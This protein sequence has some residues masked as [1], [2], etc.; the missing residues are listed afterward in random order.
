MIRRPPR[1]TLFP[2]T[3]L[4][5]SY[6]L[7]VVLYEML[8]GNLPHD[9][10][11]P[12]ALAVKHVSEPAQPPKEVNPEIPDGMNALVL[13][14]LA[15]RAEDRHASAAEVA[16]DLRRVGDGLSPLGLGS[17]AT[18]M[19]TPS[20]T[21]ASATT[22]IPLTAAASEGKKRTQTPWVLIAALVLFAL[23]GGSAW[24]LLSGSQGHDL[25]HNQE[26]SQALT[27]VPDPEDEVTEA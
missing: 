15:K 9:A 7:G 16:E 5:R 11:S 22:P 19:A 8:T 25:A 3:T 10:D 12:L 20:Q 6:S 18:A 1:S 24:S 2:Y 23:L 17:A 26:D 21:S 14:L 4:F 27:P 13:R